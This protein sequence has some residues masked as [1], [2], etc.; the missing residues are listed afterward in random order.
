MAT[1]ATMSLQGVR[2][3]EQ[4]PTT[5]GASDTFT[6][7]PGSYLYIANV[8]AGTIQPTIDGDGA[9]SALEVPGAGTKDLS[10]G[11]Q[12]ATTVA[13]GDHTVIPLDTIKEYLAGTIAVTGGDGAEA[14]ILTP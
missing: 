6:Y 2:E 11:Y 3:K 9:P 13:I 5:L 10:A 1:I 8:T 4:T 14:I 7:V 12:W